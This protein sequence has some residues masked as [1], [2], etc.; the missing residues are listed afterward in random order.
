MWESWARLQGSCSPLCRS[1]SST[2]ARLV[3]MGE[4]ASEVEDV[5]P[6]G[7]GVSPGLGQHGGPQAPR[8]RCSSKHQEG[9][10]GLAHSQARDEGCY[11]ATH[12]GSK[13]DRGNE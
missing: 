7:E 2:S 13:E 1:M 5:R 10:G 9:Q 12:P 11:E 8:H 6:G 3:G 4:E